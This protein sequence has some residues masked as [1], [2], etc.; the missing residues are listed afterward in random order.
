M[1]ENR[2]LLFWVIDLARERETFF[3]LVPEK[4]GDDRSLQA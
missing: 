1:L 3:G 2:H 4:S